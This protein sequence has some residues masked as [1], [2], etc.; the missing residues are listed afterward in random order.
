MLICFKNKVAQR[1]HETKK[2][3]KEIEEGCIVDAVHCV[4]ITETFIHC[5]LNLLEFF[6]CGHF[7]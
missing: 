1:L 2:K 4:F 5:D 7:V 6:V 3:K